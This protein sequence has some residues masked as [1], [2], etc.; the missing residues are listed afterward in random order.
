MNKTLDATGVSKYTGNLEI[1]QG[2]GKLDTFLRNTRMSGTSSALVS[3]TAIGLGAGAFYAATTGAAG[4]KDFT[5]TDDASSSLVGSA[6]GY[7]LSGAM[8]LTAAYTG[9]IA[10]GLR[11]VG[12]MAQQYSATKSKG[13]KNSKYGKLA[14]VLKPALALSLVGAVGAGCAGGD[15]SNSGSL[16][17]IAEKGSEKPGLF[18]RFVNSKYI[19][20]D[21][22]EDKDSHSKSNF[23]ESASEATSES[24]ST[25]NKIEN[26]A[27]AAF[28]FLAGTSLF[29]SGDYFQNHAGSYDGNAL[30]E[31]LDK[32]DKNGNHSVTEKEFNAVASDTQEA[33]YSGLFEKPNGFSKYDKSRK[34]KDRCSS[35]CRKNVRN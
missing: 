31:L 33:R 8:L 24:T 19:A 14:S 4:V 5:I 34:P 26:G 16:E 7:G 11:S 32:A 20:G 6:A 35:L 10:A 23:S 18:D 27:K 12:M 9:N 15:E 22:D 3:G 2:T 1:Y 25:L 13:D 28:G 30:F 29:S 21:F 17:T